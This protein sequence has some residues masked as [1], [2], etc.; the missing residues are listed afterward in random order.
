MMTWCDEGVV[1]GVCQTLFHTKY[2]VKHVTR[3]KYSSYS[4]P[5]FY[6]YTAATGNFPSK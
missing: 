4:I 6:S 1:C 5:D 3:D 2:T